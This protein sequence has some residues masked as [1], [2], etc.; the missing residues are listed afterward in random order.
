MS[1]THVPE[2][3]FPDAPRYEPG[4]DEPDADGYR[5]T[6]TVVAASRKPEPE[7][8]EGFLQGIGSSMGDIATGVGEGWNGFQN[9]LT[10]LVLRGTDAI[11]LTEGS[12]DR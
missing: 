8:D 3:L 1:S 4:T 6:G 9:D 11:G 7:A 12:L 10:G 5:D 2:D